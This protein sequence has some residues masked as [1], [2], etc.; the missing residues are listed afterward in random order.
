MAPKE[1][2]PIRI[3]EGAMEH[4][5]VTNTPFSSLHALHMSPATLFE[6]WRA[7]KNPG[8]SWGL[9]W[10]LAFEMC[11][12]FYASHGIVPWVISHEG[13][14]YYG[15]TLNVLP[16]AVNGVSDE[17]L[18]RFTAGGDAENWHT[19]S[20]GDHGCNLIEPCSNGAP[21]GSLIAS[22]VAHFRIPPFP[23]KSH[24]SCRHKR[25]GASYELCFEIA[26]L[27]ALRFESEELGIWNH[28]EHT[29][30]AIDQFDPDKH[31]KDHPGA[32]LF[33]A[34]GSEVLLA[35]DGRL[36]DGSHLNVW[37]EYMTGTTAIALSNLIIERL[38]A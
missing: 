10:F 32:F 7:I 6:H 13:L 17:S 36:L 25:W 21:T 1:P 19:G 37:K 12:R 16:C 24:L 29:R 33:T 2:R 18:G 34:N 14:G 31:M 35:A 23:S 27:I 3:L 26:T 9:A 38:D 28:P 30:R 4:S 5:F 15:I 20:P 8:R 11:K 22:A